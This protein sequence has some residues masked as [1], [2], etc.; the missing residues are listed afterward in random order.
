MINLIF[1]SLVNTFL[2]GILKNNLYLCYPYT[3][4]NYANIS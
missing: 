3:T 2:F 4:F 1:A